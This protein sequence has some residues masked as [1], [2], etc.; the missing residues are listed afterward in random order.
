MRILIIFCY[1]TEIMKNK[2]KFC[3]KITVVYFCYLKNQFVKKTIIT[4][5]NCILNV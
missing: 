4:K 2:S 5:K 1:Y 3:L